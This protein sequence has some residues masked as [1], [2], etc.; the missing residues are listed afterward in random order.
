MAHPHGGTTAPKKSKQPVRFVRQV[1]GARAERLTRRLISAV[2][3][4]RRAFLDRLRVHRIIEAQNA[5]NAPQWLQDALAQL[6]PEEVANILWLEMHGD[7]EEGIEDAKQVLSISGHFDLTPERA[8]R[9]LA[10]HVM[11]FAQDMVVNERDDLRAFV[12]DG[13]E[14]GGGARKLSRKLRDHFAEGIHYIGKDGRTVERTVGIEAWADTVAR[15]EL[16]RAYNQGA[17][18]LY[19]EAGVKE[20]VWVDAGDAHECPDCEAADGE[21]AKI[22]SEFPSVDVVDPPAHPRCFCV[23]IA[24]PEAIARYNSPENAA[25]RAEILAQNR[26]WSKAHGGRMG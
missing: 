1:R 25:R 22:G 26:A 10:D 12:T 9:Y 16:S 13:L 11:D 14:H 3:R 19:E 23:C 17:R 8:L 2:R 20:R 24:S 4:M 18:S 15:T 6:T 21:V 7:L 5:D